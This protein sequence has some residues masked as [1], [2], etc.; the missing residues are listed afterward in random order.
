MEIIAELEGARRGL[1]CGAI[2]RGD[3]DGELVASM[4]IRTVVVDRRAG[5]ARYF[6]GGGIVADSDPAREV[7]ETRWK[8]LQVTARRADGTDS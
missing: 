2:V 3:A 5:T 4:A 8:A 6:A 1:Y 7:A